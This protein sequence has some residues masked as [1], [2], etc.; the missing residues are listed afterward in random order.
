MPNQPPL[1][2]SRDGYRAI[3]VMVVVVALECTRASA[4]SVRDGSL[5]GIIPGNH[6]QIKAD[7]S[8]TRQPP[9]SMSHSMGG[10]AYRTGKTGVDVNRVLVEAGIG[11]DV[12]KIVTLRA[13]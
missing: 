10:M 7:Q 12:R 2:A 6:V 11:K 1:P 4:S 5:A 9:G 13:E 3:L 8:L